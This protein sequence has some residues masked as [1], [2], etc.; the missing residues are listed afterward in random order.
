MIGDAL[1]MISSRRGNH[2][3]GSLFGGEREQLVQR[4]PFFESSGSLLVVELK[5]DLAVGKRRKGFR[6]GAGRNANGCAYPAQRS[7]NILDSDHGV[8]AVILLLGSLTRDRFPR[9]H[10]A[11]C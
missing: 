10:H 8:R 7:L 11:I 1:R 5:E 9:G 4:A 3:L 2:A 6:V